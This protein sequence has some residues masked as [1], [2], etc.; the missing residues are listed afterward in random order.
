M[1]KIS[2]KEFDRKFDAG[3]DIDEYVDWDHAKRPGLE[4]KHINVGFPQWVVNALDKEA[5]RLGVPR[6]SVI[7]TIVANELEKKLQRA[8]G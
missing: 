7:K 6:Q 2:A 8:A 1:K 4:I 3:E 5:S